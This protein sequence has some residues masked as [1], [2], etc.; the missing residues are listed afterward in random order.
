MLKDFNEFRVGI[1]EIHFKMLVDKINE[2]KLEIEYPITP[3]NLNDFFN[4]ILAI[5]S[6][7]FFELLEAYHDWNSR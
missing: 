1:Q 6:I 4:K 2:L 5:N 7:A 3:A